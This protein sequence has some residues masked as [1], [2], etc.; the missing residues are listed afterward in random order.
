M[1][2]REVLPSNIRLITAPIKETE[3]ATLLVMYKVGSRYEDQGNRGISHF[4]EHLMFKGTEKRPNTMAIAKELDGIG[5]EFNAFTSKD[6]TGYYVKA[7]TKHLSIAIEVLSDMVINSKFD[8]IEIEREKGV[9]IEEVNMYEDNPM[10]YV[11]DLLEQSVFTGDKLGWSIIGT[12]E[13]VKKTTREDIIKYKNEHYRASNIVIA[14]A[15]KY[16]DDDVILL[17]NKF[18][19]LV[20][21]V[22]SRYKN[23]DLVQTEARVKIMKKET[24]QTQVA[25]GFPA[26]SYFNAK[27]HALRVLSTILGGNMSSRLWT[28]VRER[29]GLAYSVHASLSVY[30]DTGAL[31]IQAGLDKTRLEQ[32][33]QVIKTE[34]T[35][36]KDGVTLEEL[37]LAK[38]YLLGKMSLDLEDS[39]SI[40]QWYASQEL[41]QKTVLTP[42]EKKA[43]IMAVTMEDVKEVA[44]EV[45]NFNKANLAIIGPVAE[46]NKFLLL[47]KS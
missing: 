7:D 43:K 35:K 31:V 4:I 17:K 33:L 8:A 12:R 44:N 9:I 38:D 18:S 47:L 3:A 23:F 37:K 27:I 30:E 22:E 15:G 13:S 41:L 24:E 19:Y 32:A 6:Y 42:D 34:L 21:E 40:A 2:Q 1:Y 29:N 25:L 36:I 45:I 20:D 14:L 46:E 26:Y 10:F 28:Q 5:A 39:A 11:D 16:T